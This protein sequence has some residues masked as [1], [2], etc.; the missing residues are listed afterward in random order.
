MSARPRIRLTREG[1]YY[2]F[3]LAFIVGGAVLREAN[4]L[5]VLASLMV[6]PMLFSWR[7]VVMTMRRVAVR[8]QVVPRASVGD[9]VI[10]TV[11]MK[12]SRRSLASWGITVTD[13]VRELNRVAG[14]GAGGVLEKDN[15]VDVYFP[16]VPAGTECTVDYRL[17]LNRRG[18]YRLGPLTLSTGFPFDFLRSTLEVDCPAELLVC[19]AV[20]QFTHQWDHQIESLQHGQQRTQRRRGLAEGDYYGLREWRPG[21]SRRW[22]HWR[23]SAKM[24]AVSVL[25]FEELRQRDLALVIDLWQPGQPSP[26]DLAYVEFAVSFAATASVELGRRGSNELAMAVAGRAVECWAATASRMLA[27]EILDYLATSQG[28]SQID[29]PAAFRAL[30]PKLRRGAKL[31]VIS[32]RSAEQARNALPA[33]AELR[34]GFEFVAQWLNVR[35]ERVRSCIQFSKARVE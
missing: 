19:P 20:G 18:R 22:I 35:E 12:N 15:Q 13:H 1:R 21:D 28:G 26:Q 17:S 30:A 25:Q 9:S 23:T 10:V 29:L 33:D 11:M 4:L 16:V 2:L 24:G 31:L 7:A 27:Q 5:V 8:R 32:T 14:P 34:H 6:G 3:V